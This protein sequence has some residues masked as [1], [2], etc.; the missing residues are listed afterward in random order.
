MNDHVVTVAETESL[1]SG[2]ALRLKKVDIVG[3]DLPARWKRAAAL[4][5][6]FGRSWL[7]GM[8]K[9]HAGPFLLPEELQ[10]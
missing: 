1:A 10:R 7:D 3:N 8:A 9:T 2:V 6:W 4:L 5:R